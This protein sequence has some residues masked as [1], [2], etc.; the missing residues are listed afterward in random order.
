[1]N[2]FEFCVSH[3]KY[4]QRLHLL[5]NSKGFSVFVMGKHFLEVMVPCIFSSKIQRMNER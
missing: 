4:Y 5:H 3:E 2:I 1:M